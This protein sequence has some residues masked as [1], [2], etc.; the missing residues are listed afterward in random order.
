MD[1]N[2]QR[3]HKFNALI[4][5]IFS[6][7]LTLTA[8]A[9]GGVAYA[10][11]AGVATGVTSVL[12]TIV[13]L[14]RFNDT[15]K[16]YTIVAIPTAAS[17][18]LSI[19]EGGIP[20]MFNLY[21]LAILLI[22]VYFRRRMVVIFGTTFGVILTVIFAVAPESILGAELAVM[23][24]FVPR[25][26]VYAC[27][28]IVMATLTKWGNEHIA[29]AHTESEQAKQ[30]SEN[31][32]VIIHEIDNTAVGMVDNVKLCHDQMSTAAE[33]AR[34]ITDSMKEVA[35]N[36]DSGAEKIVRINSVALDSSVKMQET[37]DS[38]KSLRVSFDS[39][40][41][42]IDT[43]A[44]S[45]SEMGRKMTQ[46]NEAINSSYT[47]VT[48]LSGNMELIKNTLEGITRIAD[49]TNLLAL[50]AAIEAARAG[51]HGK[52]FAV[53]ADE[54]RVLAEESSRS[55]VNIREITQK[56][57]ESAEEAKTEVES[58][59]TAVSEGDLLMGSVLEV[60]TRMKGSF[61]EVH[62]Q[63]EKEMGL[64][65][66]TDQ[67]F[68]IIREEIEN[69]SASSQQN[70]A[71]TEEVLAQAEIQEETSKEVATMLDEIEKMSVE[72]KDKAMV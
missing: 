8:Y 70:A 4:I 15:V 9:N 12:V 48:E 34:A 10:V 35:I 26:G 39:T 53:V 7:I 63:I 13:A 29:N 2:M 64:I 72:L 61:D 1:Y 65:E 44:E 16:A 46:I 31:L 28:L 47:T 32:N 66:E 42:D 27:A 5:W 68:S 36:V 20:R 41:T 49:Q 24:E 3:A 69:I 18:G 17:L 59:K 62:V 50:N 25:I 58:G 54:V 14:V 37:F 51:E 71:A 55:A 21:I 43:G 6:F 67:Q 60:F 11:K 22:G 33:G 23:G 57:L 38:M 45:V 56:I 52:G 19:V 40:K 30:M